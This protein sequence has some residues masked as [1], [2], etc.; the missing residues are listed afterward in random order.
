MKGRKNT[1]LIMGALLSSI[2]VNESLYQYC[3]PF[4]PVNKRRRPQKSIPSKYRGGQKQ[5][6]HEPQ[7]VQ[8]RKIEAAEAKR[9][10][11]R[12]RNRKILAKNR[13]PETIQQAA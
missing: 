10:R 9:E 4:R 12:E 3:E 7:L 13:Q 1:G 5:H 2:F 11:R 8:Q 6:Y